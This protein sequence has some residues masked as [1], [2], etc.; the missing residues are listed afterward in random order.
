MK[1]D[2]KEVKLPKKFKTKLVK[3]LRS[4]KYKQGTG[5]LYTRFMDSYCC[6]GVACIISRNET[7]GNGC[8]TDKNNKNGK[9]PEILIGGNDKNEI[10][11]KLVSLN[12][13]K[14]RSFK[15]IASYIERYL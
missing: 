13:V 3:A 10:V 4:G 8:L 12:D 9:I 7:L 15:Y 2:G 1:I 5:Q 14:N 6:L 11:S